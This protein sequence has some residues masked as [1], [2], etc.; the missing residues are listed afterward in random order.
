MAA[1]QAV[2]Q[3]AAA[4][5]I[6]LQLQRH[7]LKPD[8]ITFAS[9]QPHTLSYFE[10]NPALQISPPVWPP[11]AARCSGVSSTVV[12]TPALASG[13]ARFVSGAKLP[14]TDAPEGE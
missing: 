4:A 5:G 7:F 13:P 2:E 11:A 10:C 9:L 12:P 1:R 8:H 6:N 14:S 3:Q